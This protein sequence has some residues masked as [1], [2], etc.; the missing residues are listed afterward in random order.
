M[1]KK[2]QRH[3]AIE[4]KNRLEYT[5]ELVRLANKI[6]ETKPEKEGETS[7][8]SESDNKPIYSNISKALK[9]FQ[10]MIDFDEEAN[11]EILVKIKNAITTGIYGLREELPEDL[12]DE[13]YEKDA[14]IDGD[15][16]MIPY[17]E[18]VSKLRK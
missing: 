4:S 3:I 6:Q 1:K 5:I 9:V 7:M 13:T 11:R 2:L 16:N 8:D 15:S 18:I 14:S 12:Q 10:Y 17:F